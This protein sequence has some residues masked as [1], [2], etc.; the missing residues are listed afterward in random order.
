MMRRR[1]RRRS[2]ERQVRP[3]EAPFV[4]KM[5]SYLTALTLVM[6]SIQVISGTRPRATSSS[7]VPERLNLESDSMNASP[8]STLQSNSY[9]T[10]KSEDYV[11]PS[12]TLPDWIKSYL[13]WHQEQRVLF[14]GN[15]LFM[16]PKA[17]KL[18]IRMCL[19]LC[20]G[21]ND[22]LGQLPWDLYLANQTGRLLLLHWHRPVPI[23]EFL[24]P[25]ELDWRVP[26]DIE[27]F[28]GDPRVSREGMKVARGIKE[29]FQGFAQESGPEHLFWDTQFDMAMKRAIDGEFKETKVLRHRLLGHLDEDKLEERLRDLG[30]TDM[31]HSSPSYGSIYRM[32][33]NLNPNVQSEVDKVYRALRL[34]PTL[35]NTDYPTSHSSYSYN[36]FSTYSAVHCRVRHPKATPKATLVKGKD[37]NYPADKTG[38][39]WNDGK[40]R[41]FAVETATHALQ[42]AN[43]LSRLFEPIYFFS[44]SN[45]LVRYMS[46]E[47]SDELFLATNK[48]MLRNP[49]DAKALEVVSMSRV[50]AR[51]VSTDTVHIDRQKGR[52]P[53]AYFA[54]FVDLD[55]AIHARCVTF[56]VGFYAVFATR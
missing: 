34:R 39:P 55:I 11:L 29:L 19:G 54:T 17:P 37:A 14:P 50:V 49:T 2:V 43:T 6:V 31:L 9:Y 21:L 53:E 15:A 38:L 12:S 42:C 33:F 28:F 47:L 44:D 25:R 8:T 18:L 41:Q 16:H 1:T 23:E 51:N 32:F 40:A 22:R 20:G 13:K 24:L 35:Q 56:G 52:E 36:N 5:A 46:H 30:E 27:G 45:D 10:A 26:R 4:T 7:R 48:S 3:T